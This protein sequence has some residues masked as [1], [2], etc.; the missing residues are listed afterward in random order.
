MLCDDVLPWRRDLCQRSFNY[1]TKAQQD[2]L[3]RGIAGKQTVYIDPANHNA[4][5]LDTHYATLAKWW[6]LNIGRGIEDVPRDQW[7]QFNALTECGATPTDL[8]KNLGPAIVSNAAYLFDNMGLLGTD[9]VANGAAEY[10][11][12]PLHWFAPGYY[13]QYQGFGD[14]KNYPSCTDKWFNGAGVP[15]LVCWV[16]ADVPSQIIAQSGWN[17][18]DA[19]AQTDKYG[20][21]GIGQLNNQALDQKTMDV[22][23]NTVGRYFHD[24]H[25]LNRATDGGTL[26]P[27]SGGSL[28]NI[29]IASTNH[30]QVGDYVI[31]TDDTSP[32]VSPVLSGQEDSTHLAM[33][34]RGGDDLDKV[35]VAEM[36]YSSQGYFGTGR[37]AVITLRTY[38]Y[39][40]TE[41][42]INTAT[43]PNEKARIMRLANNGFAAANPQDLFDQLFIHFLHGSL[44]NAHP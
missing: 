41:A 23:V 13:P 43:D 27:A 31:I 25:V 12:R 26:V 10:N 29:H 15:A 37:F 11:L 33:V 44:N 2:N 19:M 7:N 34:V 18:H 28:P 14:T 38:L 17:L 32:W 6:L 30:Y 9:L 24:F 21:K 4:V 20:P 5:I 22:D 36:S 16:C 3:L 39:L 1:L 40:N 42:R 8:C 35:L